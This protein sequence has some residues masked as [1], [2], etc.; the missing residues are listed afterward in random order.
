MGEDKAEY[1]KRTKM[2]AHGK[3]IQYIYSFPVFM[4]ISFIHIHVRIRFGGK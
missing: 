2:Q 3:Y 1:N 4:F